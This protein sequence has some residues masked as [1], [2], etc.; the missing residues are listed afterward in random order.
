MARA[1]DRIR[2]TTAIQII[3]VID[4]LLISRSVYRATVRTSGSSITFQSNNFRNSRGGSASG[5]TSRIAR[6]RVDRA[7]PGSAARV[8]WQRDGENSLQNSGYIQKF[9]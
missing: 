7:Q 8:L 5:G 3:Q 6:K 9:D 1:T 4:I 2:A